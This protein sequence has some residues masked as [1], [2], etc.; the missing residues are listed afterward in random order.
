MFLCLR[1]AHLQCRQRHGWWRVGVIGPPFVQLVYVLLRQMASDSSVPDSW[2]P[3]PWTIYFR[4]LVIT[5]SF[6]ASLRCN[7]FKKPPA[8][9]TAQ[10]CL[11]Q[12]R[13]SCLP[14][15]HVATYLSSARESQAW[16][17]WAPV[18][19]HTR[20]RHSDR[21]PQMSTSTFPAAHPSP[22]HLSWCLSGWLRF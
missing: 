1:W 2:P 17:W 16:L 13:G 9:F 10:N 15:W 4:K 7:S 6:S 11:S 20:P 18:S 8:S 22:E 14:L 19:K 3:F 5:N 12:G 21:L